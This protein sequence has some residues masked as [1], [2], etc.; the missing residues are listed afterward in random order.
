MKLPRPRLLPW[1]GLL[2]IT[3][4]LA[5]CGGNST[6]FSTNASSS[7]RG[8]SQT[9]PASSGPVVPNFTVSNGEGTAFSLG[10]H[11]GDVVVLYFSFP[12]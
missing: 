11:Q 4:I 5:A 8:S 6:G 3:L 12:G 7:Q 10:D 1:S 2:I 9:A